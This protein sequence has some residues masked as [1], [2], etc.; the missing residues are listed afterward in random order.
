VKNTVSAKKVTQYSI[1]LNI[2]KAN[3]LGL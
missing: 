3:S 2:S 1:I